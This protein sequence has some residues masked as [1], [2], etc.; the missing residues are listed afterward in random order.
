MSERIPSKGERDKP[1]EPGGK[2]KAGAY[3]DVIKLG[4][5]VVFVI[6]A[7][8]VLMLAFTRG[9]LTRAY[10]IA[11]YIGI[12]IVTGVIFW[13]L[14]P[15]STGEL[16]L[17]KLGI[18]LGG[19]AAIGAIFM[20]LAHQLTVRETNYVVLPI[21]A[22]IHR[23]FTIKNLSPGDISN[24]GQVRTITHKRLLFVEFRPGKEAGTIRLKYFRTNDSKFEEPVY[25]VTLKG[26]LT[27]DHQ[28]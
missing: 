26:E 27:K 12:A 11:L 14:T 16:E 28:H 6:I 2:A 19:G 23:E 15:G 3:P 24:V 5:A 7:L 4:M 18:K 8:E 20:I 21:P 22:Q 13:L 25:R 17:K 9:Q 10:E 1:N